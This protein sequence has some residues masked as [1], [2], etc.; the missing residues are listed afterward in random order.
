MDVTFLKSEPFFSA[1][2]SALQGGTRDEEQNWVHC[3]WPNKDTM[4]GEA[5]QSRLDTGP[6][7]PTKPNASSEHDTPSKIEPSP[8]F[9][10][11]KSPISREYP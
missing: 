8:P 11:T 9:R 5:P 7:E 1:P 10:N 6:D 3:D 4:I 2:N